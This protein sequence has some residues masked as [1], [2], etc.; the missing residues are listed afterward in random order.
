MFRDQN[1]FPGCG[2]DPDP[3]GFANSNSVFVWPVS[4][5]SVWIRL[6]PMSGK[7]AIDYSCC[8]INK[9]FFVAL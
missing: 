4:I 2:L 3:L 7:L 8:F 1:S 6:A 5:I 9:T